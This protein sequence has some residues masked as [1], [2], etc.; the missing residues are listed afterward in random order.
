VS[1]AIEDD[2][3]F[4]HMQRRAREVVNS[5][6]VAKM[7]FCAC[8][9]ATIT[10]PTHGDDDTTAGAPTKGN[11]VSTIDS[12]NHVAIDSVFTGAAATAA[13]ST[14]GTSTAWPHKKAAA[15]H[16]TECSDL[17]NFFATCDNQQKGLT[18]D[19][20]SHDLESCCAA[21]CADPSCQVCQYQNCSESLTHPQLHADRTRMH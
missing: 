12:S 5:R 10:S 20:N 7:L 14:I 6:Q 11:V 15:V 13:A 19:G 21:C 1:V 9:L 2:S 8:V 3:L 18:A 17:T 4:R 16:T